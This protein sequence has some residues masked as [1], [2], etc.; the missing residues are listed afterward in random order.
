MSHRESPQTGQFRLRDLLGLITGT[1]IFFAA[2]APYFRTLDRAAQISA[3]VKASTMAVLAIGMMAF[4]VAKRRR[5]E[6]RAGPLIERF[7]RFSSRVVTVLIALAL[8]AAYASSIWFQHSP[9]PGHRGPAIMPGSPILLLFA[10]NYLVLRVWWKIDPLCLEAC[11]H[12][13]V[14]GGFQFCAWDDIRRFTWSG[15]P[16][17]QLNLFLRQQLV[18][19]LKVDTSSV[20][21]L[22]RILDQQVAT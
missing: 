7:G 20:E 1:A 13:L 5:A 15:N 3:A 16:A 9:P 11:E 22:E 21:G 14:I 10:V 17:R 19:N 8:C 12:G 2:F 4:L 6:R 18:L